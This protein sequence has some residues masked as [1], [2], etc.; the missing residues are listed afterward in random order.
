MP[1]K[2]FK[3]Q[4]QEGHSNS[5]VHER[6]RL[7]GCDSSDESDAAA[8]FSFKWILKNCRSLCSDQRIAELLAEADTDHWDCIM[9]NETWREQKADNV[10]LSCGRLWFGS[11]GRKGKHGVGILLH[12]RWTCAKP[13]WKPLT[14]RLGALTLS[15]GSWSALFIVAY[16]KASP[17]PPAPLV[18][19]GFLVAG[20]LAWQ[21]SDRP[22]LVRFCC[23]VFVLLGSWMPDSWHFCR[24]RS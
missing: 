17:L 10:E 22:L 5:H 19:A 7:R 16:L 2:P 14:E 20:L 24:N 21:Y 13:V 6:L 4:V 11:G 9:V 1:Q 15:F 8:K 23:L 18:V 3:E 12:R